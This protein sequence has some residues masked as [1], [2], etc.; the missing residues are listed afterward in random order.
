MA[1]VNKYH[2]PQAKRRRQV[3][4]EA[5]EYLC[6]CP[7]CLTLETLWFRHDVLVPTAKFSQEEDGGV[8]HDC[9]GSTG[10]CRLFPSWEIKPRML[11]P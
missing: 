2:L 9:N 4:I 8:Y 10:P 7:R 6:Q 3:A 1:R 5:Q 11:Q